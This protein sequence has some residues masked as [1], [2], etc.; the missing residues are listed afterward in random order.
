MTVSS[1]K[2]ARSLNDRYGCDNQ[3]FRFNVDQ[4]LRDITLSDWKKTSR[5]SAHTRNYLAE[6][7]WAIRG[8][9]DNLSRRVSTDVNEHKPPTTS[10]RI[11]FAVPFRRNKNFVGRQSI[12][13]QLLS[14]VPP[15]VDADDCQRTGI[16]GLGGI[17]KTQIALEISFRV[18]EMHSDCSIYWVPAIDAVSFRNAYRNIGQLLEINGINDD[19]ADV[20][21]F[22]KQALS[23]ESAGSWLMIVDNADSSA[24]FDG[25]TNL[26]RHLPFSRRGSLLFTSRNRELIVQLGVP[27]TNLFVVE[28]MGGNEGF[29]LLETHLTSRQ[30]SD[31]ENTEK[32]LNALNYLPLA[33]KQASTYMA[34]K[35]ISTTKY[36]QIASRVTEK[37]SRY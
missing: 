30:I 33:I 21:E 3:Y 23:H 28:G 19:K 17:G 10:G 32:L 35:Q 25:S 31:R 29:K 34:K 8:F 11:T 20:E 14:I 12:I 18:R 36:L 22:V 37:W 7:G 5:I 6:N 1:K 4:G 9:I 26:G 15:G 24:L 2:V 27:V 16:V 13:E